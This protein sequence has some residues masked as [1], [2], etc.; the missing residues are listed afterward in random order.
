MIEAKEIKMKKKT[1][2]KNEVEQSATHSGVDLINPPATPAFTDIAF[3]KEA[4]RRNKAIK[5]E[6]KKISSSFEKIAFHLHWFYCNAA[7]KELGYDNIYAFASKEYCIARGTTNNY[8]NVVERFAERGEHGEILERI[9]PELRDFQSSK[10]IALLD[11]QDDELNEFSS[12]MSVRDIKKKVK[13]MTSSEDSEGEDS[14]SGESG[15]NDS[16]DEIRV[17]ATEINRQTVVTFA[18]F[19]EYNKYLDGM[20]DLI[21]K[22]LKSKAFKDGNKKIEVAIVW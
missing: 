16:R 18:S 22:A 5:S 7:Y 10:L 14:E 2:T 15:S 17:T 8:I 6:L 11:V 9:R 13:D 20:N 12:D 1:T 19:D 4:D 3:A 21:E